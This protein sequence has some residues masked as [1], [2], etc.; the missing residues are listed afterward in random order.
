[1]AQLKEIL[2][3][4]RK[5]MEEGP[6]GTIQLFPEGTFYR[7]YEWSAW[8]CCR[9]INQFKPTRREVKGEMG[10]TVVFIGFPV[11]SLGKFLPE[12]AQMVANDDKSVT[13]TLLMS[14]AQE[15]D[16]PKQG[17]EEWKTSVPLVAPRRGSVKEELKNMRD[18]QPHRMSEVMLRILAFPVEQKTPME[19]MAFVA[20]LKQDLAKLL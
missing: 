5:R 3:I 16:L 13:I 12:D 7:A 4:E 19:C 9:F 14:V 10:E 1:M 2:E 6:W 11:T 18:D 20:E 8:L 15:Q 17:F